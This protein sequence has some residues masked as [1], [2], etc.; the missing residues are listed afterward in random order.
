M[1]VSV[2]IPA[3][4][5][6]GTIGKTICAAM[7]IRPS[8]LVVSVDEQTTD[9]TYAEAMKW[10]EYFENVSV[11][12]KAPH[13]KGQCI[14][15]ALRY[16]HTERVILLDADI[17]GWQEK[18][19]A[20]EC[21]NSTIAEM[22]IAVPALP[23]REEL[24]GLSLT[25]Q[26]RIRLAWPHVSGLRTVPLTLLNSIDLHGYLVETQ[27]NIE[28]NKRGLTVWYQWADHLHNAFNRSRTR[29]REMEEDREWGIKNGVLEAPHKAYQRNS[30]IDGSGYGKHS[31]DGET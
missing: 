26:E 9:Q 6:E 28:A 29:L 15:H 7:S 20:L 27:L 2:I 25:M 23:T 8:L 12:H 22:I 4:N 31:G 18:D 5:E 3:R 21:L 19:P 17:T 24:H 10:P 16:V 1:S 13:G 11:L 30:D 14:K